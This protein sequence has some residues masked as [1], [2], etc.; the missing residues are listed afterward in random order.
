MTTETN[1]PKD[2]RLPKYYAYNPIEGNGNAKSV[3]WHRIGTVFAHDDGEGETLILDSLPIHFDGRI[4]MR[5][6]KVEQGAGE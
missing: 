4:V 5:A 2:A 6:P 3:R 1:K